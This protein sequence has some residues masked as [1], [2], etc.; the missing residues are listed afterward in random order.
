MPQPHPTTKEYDADW[1]REI[2]AEGPI[3][4]LIEAIV[5]NGLVIDKEMRIWQRK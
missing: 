4:L 1:D 5:W 3:G 2:Q